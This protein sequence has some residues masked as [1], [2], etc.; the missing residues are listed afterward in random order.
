MSYYLPVDVSLKSIVLDNSV[1][2]EEKDISCKFASST[3]LSTFSV[4]FTPDS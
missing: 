2:L 1:A 4:L 3:S